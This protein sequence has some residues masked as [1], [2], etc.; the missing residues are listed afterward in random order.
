MSGLLVFFLLYFSIYGT[1]HLYLLI[2]WRRA[3]YLQGVQYVLLFAIL[4]FLMLAPINA[5]LLETQGYWLPALV[6]T[7]AGYLWM[8]FVFIYLCLALP[9]DLYHLLLSLGQRLSGGDWTALMLSR[10]QSAVLATVLAVVLMAYGVVEAR[11]ISVETVTLRSPKIPGNTAPIRIVQ[12]S[13]LHL[14][15]MLYPGRLTPI[16]EAVAQAHPDILVC[17]GD[18]VDGRMVNPAS[19]M[20]ALR[21]LAAPMGKFAVTGNHEYYFGLEKAVDFIRDSGFVL[22][23]NQHVSAGPHVAIIG[24]DDPAGGKVQQGSSEMQL[25]AAVP[26]DKFKLL[27][28]HRPLLDANS[29]NRFDLQLSGHTHQ[30]QIFPFGLL[31]QLFFPVGQGLRQV[32]PHSYIYTSRGTGTWGPPIRL[33]A[34]PEITVFDI[35][36]G[37]IQSAVAPS[38]P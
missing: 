24:L 18:L 13:D 30:G 2:K 25:L 6:L 14:G 28:K 31:V 1:V 20:A 4:T 27:L 11:R 22:L 21:N 7:W 32:A 37:H 19:V 10:R 38:Q 15:P 12:I 3:F 17:T 23:R 33:L 36:P 26:D 29:K 5:H 9:L 8:G 34:P 16:I 35:L